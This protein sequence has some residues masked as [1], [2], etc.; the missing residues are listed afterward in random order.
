[1]Y[2]VCHGQNH[3]CG[4]TDLGRKYLVQHPRV[5][6]EFLLSVNAGMYMYTCSNVFEYLFIHKCI[7]CDYIPNLS[8]IKG[9]FTIRHKNARIGSKDRLGSFLHSSALCSCIWAR[10][11]WIALRKLDETHTPLHHILISQ[12]AQ[13][14]VAPMQCGPYVHAV[15]TYMCV[16]AAIIPGIPFIG[17]LRYYHHMWQRHYKASPYLSLDN[18]MSNYIASETGLPDQMDEHNRDSNDTQST[19]IDQIPRK[20][21]RMIHYLVVG[22]MYILTRVHSYNFILYTS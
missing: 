21:H 17:Y 16:C 15:C 6:E 19:A 18:V 20:V 22:A 11:S 4:G 8:D 13:S 1:M 5:P 3:Y 12:S 9:Q 2:I 10:K 14:V 7:C